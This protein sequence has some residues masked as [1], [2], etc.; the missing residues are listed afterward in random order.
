M[1]TLTY[2]TGSV[3]LFST[4]PTISLENSFSSYLWLRRIT[5][6]PPGEALTFSLSPLQMVVLWLRKEKAGMKRMSKVFIVAEFR[7]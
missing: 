3:H 1:D 4:S 2:S 7:T 6:P 5:L